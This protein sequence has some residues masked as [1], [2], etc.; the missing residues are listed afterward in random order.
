MT[1][2]ARVPN[3]CDVCCSAARRMA[4]EHRRTAVKL[5]RHGRSGVILLVAHWHGDAVVQ[6]TIDGPMSAEQA[7]VAVAQ[8]DRAI[9]AGLAAGGAQGGVA[10]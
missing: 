7:A 1:N 9:A 6:W 3:P 8:L 4:L 5:C 2:F 10:H